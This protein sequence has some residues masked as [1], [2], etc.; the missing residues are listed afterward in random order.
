MEG[1]VSRSFETARWYLVVG[2]EI[3]EAFQNG[4]RHD[5]HD[6]LVSAALQKVEAII[7]GSVARGTALL[8]SSLNLRVA[9][10]RGMSVREAVAKLE[11]G[12]LHLLGPIGDD[13]SQQVGVPRN[14]GAKPRS[15]SGKSF[16]SVA[17]RAQHHLQQYSGRGH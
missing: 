8:M 1:A 9:Y 7:A 12:D 3:V 6:A 5:R 14:G 17:T 11:E 10:A 15:W 16:P 4:S 13:M 2:G